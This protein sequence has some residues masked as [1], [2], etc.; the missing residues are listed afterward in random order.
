VGFQA[1]ENS[2]T[3]AQNT[4]LGYQ[5]MEEVTTGQ[6]NVAIGAFSA[7][8]LTTGSDNTSVGYNS[9]TNITTANQSVCVGESAL[10]AVTTGNRNIGIGSKAGDMITTGAENTI[11]GYDAGSFTTG[12]VTGDQNVLLGAF[13]HPNAD[14]G[15]AQIVMGYNVSGTGNST[16]TFGNGTSDTT[17]SF[18]STSWSNPSD[19]RLKE[20]IE[21]EKIGLDFINELRPVT[22]LWKKEKDVPA[23]MKAHVPDSEERVMNGKHNHGFIAQEVKEVI[24]R[25]DLKDG[26]DMWTEEIDGRQRIGESALMPMMVKAVQELSAEVEELK[27]KSHEKCDK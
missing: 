9:L 23:D 6:D 16:F 17:I 8:T 10:Q 4:A 26:F 13:V 12:L 3:G 20:D 24:D 27:S 19:I 1:L 22:F 7:D 5:A 14:G 11:I 21:D 15:N 25:Y 2:T 18:G